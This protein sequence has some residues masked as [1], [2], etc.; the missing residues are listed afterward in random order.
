MKL[1]SKKKSIEKAD[2]DDAVEVEGVH[3]ATTYSAEMVSLYICIERKSCNL[4][5]FVTKISFSHWNC[6]V[7][8]LHKWFWIDS[9]YVP[10]LHSL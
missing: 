2:D 1:I 7:C 9:L 10:L 3:V 5:R 4:C 6:V 8:V